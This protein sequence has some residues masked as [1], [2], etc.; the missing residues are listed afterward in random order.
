M[1]IAGFGTVFFDR[2]WSDDSPK[3]VH[4]PVDRGGIVQI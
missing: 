3:A 1:P 2:I 4:K